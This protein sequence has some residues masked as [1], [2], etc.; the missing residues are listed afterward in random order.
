VQGGRVE[1]LAGAFDESRLGGVAIAGRQGSAW[2]SGHSSARFLVYSVTKT[3]IAVLCSRL[4][5]EGLL[6]LDAPASA[7]L[8]DARLPHGATVR[9]LLDHTSGIPDYARLASYAAAV[10]TAP[11]EPWSD[12]ELLDRALALGPDFPPGEGWAYSNTGYLLLRRIVEE[13]VGEGFAAALHERVLE[14]LALGHTTVAEHPHD[15]DGLVAGRTTQLG[16]E[17]VDVRGRYH[18]GWVGHRALASSAAD[19]F[20]FW[21]ALAS[22][23][24]AGSARLLDPATWVAIGREAPGFVRPSYGLGVM[25]DPGSPLGTV[26]GHGG[27]GPGYGAAAFAVPDRRAPAVAVVLTAQDAVEGADAAALALLRVVA[28]EGC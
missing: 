16:D 3:F 26:L 17:V 27:G 7:V 1:K 15:I 10:R 22:G 8:G 13:V 19:L 12:A 23:R 11:G 24:F 25:A 6:E 21:S 4:V 9:R 5:D 18:P 2:T 14:P 28:E 20:A